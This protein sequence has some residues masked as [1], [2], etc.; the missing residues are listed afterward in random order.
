MRTKLLSAAA[1]S[2]VLSAPYALAQDT[3]VVPDTVT[4]YVTEQPMDETTVDADV[5]VG[6]TLPDQVV[7]KKVPDNDDFAY[8]VVNKQRVIVEPSTRRVIKII[9]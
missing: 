7:I 1:L 8:A 9:Q 2:V 4:T 6:N 5:A 3:V